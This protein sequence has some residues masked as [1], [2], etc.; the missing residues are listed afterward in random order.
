[1]SNSLDLTAGP[2]TWRTFRIRAKRRD[3][4]GA[5]WEFAAAAVAGPFW[6]GARCAQDDHRVTGLFLWKHPVQPRR[7]NDRS[8]WRSG[9][10]GAICTRLP[11]LG[12]RRFAPSASRIACGAPAMPAP[13]LA[14]RLHLRGLPVLGMMLAGAIRS[15]RAGL[16]SHPPSRRRYGKG[17]WRRA[18]RTAFSTQSPET[19]C[20]PSPALSIA[21]GSNQV[22]STAPMLMNQLSCVGALGDGW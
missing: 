6:K 14:G 2:R 13:A 1:V 10:A 4:S 16:S 9:P 17:P 18:G 21:V 20:P 7:L 8:V 12:S 3:L 15:D 19:P 11:T 22:R 5:L